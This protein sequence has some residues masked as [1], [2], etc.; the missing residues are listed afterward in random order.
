MD[1]VAAGF[2]ANVVD[3]VA[4]AGRDAFDDVGS[5]GDAEAEDVHERIVRVGRLERDFA[6]DGGNTDAVAIARDTGDHALDET[7]SAPGFERP[8]AERVEQ[9]DG[10]RAHRE[11]VADDATHA[12]GRALIRLDERR[13][14]VRLDFEDRRQAIADVDGAGVFTWPLEHLRPVARQR[15]QVH[16]GALVAAVLR[17]H[18]REDA[19]LGRVRLAAEEL[20]DAVVLVRRQAVAFE[21]GRHRVRTTEP[22][23][24]DEIEALALEPLHDGARPVLAAEQ[25]A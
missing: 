2:R 5:P 14:I 9:S 4:G 15:L 3:R 10:P 25:L 23:E 18:H 19:E 11:N 1:A 13:V 17:P 16:A 21:K 24:C 8:E 6:A 12:R 20:H 7:A 22:L